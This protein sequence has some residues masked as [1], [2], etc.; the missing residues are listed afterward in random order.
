M[1]FTVPEQLVTQ[2][3]A[4]IRIVP[5]FPKAG[6]SFKDITPIFAQPSLVARAADVLAEAF[7]NQGLTAVAGIESR[8]FLLGTLLAQRLNLPFILLRKK[9]K[10][11]WRTVS[12][13]YALEYGEATI[14]MHVDAIGPGDTVLIHDDLLAT[15]GTAAAAAE[16]VL[17]QGAKVGGFAFLVDLTFLPGNQRLQAYR[18]PIHSLIHSNE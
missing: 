15:G 14:E 12:H 18:A 11:P 1:S 7:A 8:G 5:D 3:E 9:G 2:L 6:I 4:Q 10:L 13:S 16:L 17:G